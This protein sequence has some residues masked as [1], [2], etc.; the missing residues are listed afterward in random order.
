MPDELERRLIGASEVKSTNQVTPG[1]DGYAAI[2]DSVADIG[3][4]FKEKIKRGAFSKAIRERQDVRALLNHSDDN[5]L[6]RVQNNTLRLSE[7]SRGLKFSIDFPDTT[8]GRDLRTLIARGDVTQCSFGFIAGT[9]SW[10]KGRN[11]EMDTREIEEVSSLFDVS[12]VTFPAYAQTSVTAR[13]NLFP[14]GIPAE[15]RRHCPGLSPTLTT[16]SEI[17][18]YLAALRKKVKGKGAGDACDC[19]CDACAAGDCSE[20]SNEDCED[21]ACRAA[22]CPMQERSA[23]RKAD[24]QL[25]RQIAQMRIEAFKD[26]DDCGLTISKAKLRLIDAQFARLSR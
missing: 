14:A 16:D 2:F 21:A 23:R 24:L 26:R 22:D 25:D 13:S 6:G 11:G 12:I 17:E 10:T 19:D 3:G 18:K 8:L 1:A 20:C 15:V 4:L 9:Q 7:D 5:I